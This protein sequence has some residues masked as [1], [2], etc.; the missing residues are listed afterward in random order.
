MGGL[1]MEMKLGSNIVALRRKKGLTQEQ[2]A[3][4]LGV[5]AAAVSK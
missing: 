4:M 5:T 2:L 3:D 1:P